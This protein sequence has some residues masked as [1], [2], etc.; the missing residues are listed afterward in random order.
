MHPCQT[1]VGLLVGKRAFVKG[2]LQI[3]RAVRQHSITMSYQL[4]MHH[5]F[6]TELIPLADRGGEGV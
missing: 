4:A 1:H 6:F 2:G 3:S 5:S